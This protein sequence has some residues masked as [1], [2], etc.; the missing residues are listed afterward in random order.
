[1]IAYYVHHHGTGHLHRAASI[2]SKLQV[3]VVGLSS[4]PPPSGWTGE[5]L[6]LDDDAAGVDLATGDV[7]AGATLHWVPQ[8]HDGLRRRMGA[9]STLL[10]TGRI[11]LLVSD[12]SV[13]VALLARLHGVPVVVV[14][15]PGER[16]DRAHRLAF[17]LADRLLAP[18]PAHPAR[19]SEPAWRAK[20]VH[21]GG[22]SRYD[23]RPRLRHRPGRR[24]LVLWGS[25]GVDV[26]LAGLVGAARATA[27]W[28]WQLAGPAPPPSGVVPTPTP[29]NL[30]H[31]GWV[32]D[33]W[34]T[35]CRADVVITHAGQNA[36]AE[37]AAARRPA[38]VIPQVRP[39]RE[40][41]ATAEA[42]A[43]S[44]L[45]T[46]VAHWPRDEEWAG[47]LEGAAARPGHPWSQWSPG[48]GAERAAR[49][50]EARLPAGPWT[51]PPTP[52]R[53]LSTGRSALPA[54]R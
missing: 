28:H 7:T 6:Q 54:G 41:E 16:T 21:L 43:A 35:L 32:E 29:S 18:W 24:V 8:H 46:V 5:W 27:G 52:D 44:G 10:A 1:L 4:R 47:L 25:G 51:V 9:I 40:Q 53:E 42:L 33:L 37:V 31:L 26:P 49:A 22:F 14:A 17:D 23:G 15:Q 3:P 45:A 12:V 30:E 19:T 38:I 13:E 39:F 34:P 20:T 2:S 50:L 11:S 36:I 48:D